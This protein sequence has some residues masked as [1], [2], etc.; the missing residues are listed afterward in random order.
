MGA[1]EPLGL[2]GRELNERR[3]DGKIVTL[4]GVPGYLVQARSVS[5]DAPAKQGGLRTRWN[6]MPPRTRSAIVVAT[7]VALLI[8]LAIIGGGEGGGGGG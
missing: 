4:P 7:F 8:A 5:V 1:R 3:P 6:R 2:P